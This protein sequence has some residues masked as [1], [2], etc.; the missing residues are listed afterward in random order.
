[1]PRRS[2]PNDPL[3]SKLEAIHSVLQ[4]LLIFEGARAGMNKKEVRQMLGVSNDRIGQIWKHI[5]IH[6][7]E[8]AN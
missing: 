5:K 3:L 4:D 8:P 1:M 7:V 2:E 6:G